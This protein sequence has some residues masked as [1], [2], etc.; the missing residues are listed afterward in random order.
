MHLTAVLRGA[1]CL[2]SYN[3]PVSPRGALGWPTT[4]R[5]RHWVRAARNATCACLT[6]DL[7]VAIFMLLDVDALVS[8]RM[9]CGMLISSSPLS[10]CQAA[11]LTCAHL[12]SS[13]ACTGCKTFAA[14]GL[15]VRQRPCQGADARDEGSCRGQSRWHR[16][17]VRDFRRCS[18]LANRF[19]SWTVRKSLAGAP[20]R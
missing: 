7:I 17:F 8:L 16:F 12:D 11:S 15:Q 9:Q 18:P 2:L 3:L 19:R 14:L 20:D 5:R 10:C 13:I 1:A 4:S 6:G